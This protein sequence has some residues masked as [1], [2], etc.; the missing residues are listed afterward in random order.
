MHICFLSH[1]YP[2]AGLNPGGVGVFLYTFCN[3]LTEAG[4]R[5]TVL[6]ANDS[7]RTED[8]TQGNLR[9]IRFA[10]PSL[11]GV[12]WWLIARKLNAYLKDINASHPLDIVESSELGLAFLQKLPN[13]KYVVRLHGGHHFFSE[14][15][16]RSINRWK[17]FQEKRSFK[18]ADAFIA[19]SD[20]VRE[21]TAKYL[22]YQGKPL[23]TI[24]YMI[25]Q[26]RFAY[27]ESYPEAKDF[28]LVFAGTI[29]EKKGVGN[30]IEAM[31]KVSLKFPEATLDIFGKEWFFPNGDS[32]TDYIQA[33]IPSN[34]KNQIKIHP[35][36]TH[37]QIPQVYGKAAICIFPSFMET[38]GLVAPEAMAM[39][40]VVIFTDKGPGPETITHGLNGFLCNPLDV[41]SIENSIITAFEAKDQFQEIGVKAYE[42]VNSVF[43][44]SNVSRNVTFYKSLI[45]G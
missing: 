37:D 41:S 10:K 12:N 4:H 20:Y 3:V 2:K 40:K 7:N 16:N 30:L 34:L 8:E 36:V 1:E 44:V 14:S 5:V 19:V 17:G 21:H 18:K 11:P 9:V 26:K 32:Y 39:G 28:S 45:N 33:R 22:S 23:A 27:K 15:E 35:P 42:K 43:N 6:G 25:D 29:C 24:R 38:Q 31:A 13:V